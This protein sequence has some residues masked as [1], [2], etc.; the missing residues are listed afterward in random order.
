[1][2]TGARVA[3]RRALIIITVGV[4]ALLA[5][6]LIGSK[7]FGFDSKS[8]PLTI[9]VLGSIFISQALHTA[10]GLDKQLGI[11]VLYSVP[12]SI[13]F[14]GVVIFV[15]EYPYASVTIWLGLATLTALISGIA[16]VHQEAS[17]NEELEKGLSFFGGDIQF[18]SGARVSIERVS[19]VEL[20][21]SRDGSG[22]LT[23]RT[24]DGDVF[25]VGPS[26]NPESIADRISEAMVR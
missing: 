3:K 12:I 1:M 11:R 24:K 2:D 4:S 9:A 20:G 6:I 21:P 16:P 26:H 7:L 13:V 14:V 17:S 18:Q 23:I 25:S 19:S 5:A 10:I 22:E 15:E 8:V